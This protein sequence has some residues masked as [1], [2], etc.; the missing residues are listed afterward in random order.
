M[1][2][3]PGLDDFLEFR[4]SL[5]I[6]IIKRFVLRYKMQMQ[7]QQ[8]RPLGSRETWNETTMCL[9]HTLETQLRD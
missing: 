5:I 6:T 1:H 4:Y 9:Q 8:R 7:T 2:N 3:I